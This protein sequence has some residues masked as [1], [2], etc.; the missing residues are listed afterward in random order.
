MVVIPASY[1][2]NFLL[3]NRTDAV[4]CLPE[5][6]KLSSSSQVVDHF[7]IQTLLKIGLPLRVKGIGFAFNLVVRLVVRIRRID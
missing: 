7:D 2:G 5:A 4:L 1:F 3:A 6:D